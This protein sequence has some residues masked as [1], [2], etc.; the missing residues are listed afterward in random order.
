MR[1]LTGMGRDAALG[2]VGVGASML[3][4]VGQ[5]AREGIRLQDIAARLSINARGAGEKGADATALRREFENA[6]IANPGVK[7]ADVAAGAAG[8]VAVIDL[9][10]ALERSAGLEFQQ[11][12]DVVQE[13][14]RN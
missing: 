13:R 4:V 3:G 2:A 5:A 1:T 6:A 11:V 10:L 14:R 12:A 8:F 7:A 9:V